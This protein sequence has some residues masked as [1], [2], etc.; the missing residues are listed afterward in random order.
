[1]PALV[2]GA[3]GRHGRS[4]D[5]GCAGAAG[6]SGGGLPPTAAQADPGLAAAPGPMDGGAV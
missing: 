4:S 3:I 1:V 6:L 5:G 2:D